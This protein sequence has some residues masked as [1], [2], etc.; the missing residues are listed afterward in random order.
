MGQMAAMPRQGGGSNKP[1][2]VLHM[3]KLLRFARHKE[4]NASA[5]FNMS[6]SQISHKLNLTDMTSVNS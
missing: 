1:F 6:Q 3:H 5:R 2:L 4:S